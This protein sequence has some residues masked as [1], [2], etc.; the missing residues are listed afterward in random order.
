MPI[1]ALVAAALILLASLTPPFAAAAPLWAG[2]EDGGRGVV[3][4]VVDGDTVTLASGASVRLVGIQAPKLP[5]GRPGF[6]KWPLA[7]KAKQRVIKL[8]MNQPV[9]LFYGGQKFDRYGRKLAQLWRVDDKGKPELWVQG[10]LLKQGLARVYTFP[11]NRALALEMLARERVARQ[12]SKGL[13]GHPFY[14]VR[15]PE[16]T[17]RLVDTFQVVGGDVASTAIVRGRGYINFG[18]DWRTDFTVS[19]APR[20]LRKFPE[21]VAAFDR[22]EGQKI[23]VRGWIKRYNGSMIEVTHP[24]QIEADDEF[25]DDDTQEDEVDD[26]SEDNQFGDGQ[27]EG[28]LGD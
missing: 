3:V 18:D 9:R 2:L 7:D 22:Y 11:D 4:D 19:V 28:L 16:D 23:Q 12:K 6:A 13:W 14:E 24:E 15:V 10:V 1:R 8:L 21:L 25:S 5:L 26:D 17:D 27:G 20:I